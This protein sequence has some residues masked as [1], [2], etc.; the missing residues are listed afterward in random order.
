MSNWVS[1]RSSDNG[2]R[3]GHRAVGGDAEVAV[4]QRRRDR[5]KAGTPVDRAV[6]ALDPGQMTLGDPGEF[7][8]GAQGHPAPGSDLSDPPTI[9]CVRPA[10]GHV[11]MLLPPPL[12]PDA[13]VVLDA[14]L[15]LQGPHEHHNEPAEIANHPD[16]QQRSPGE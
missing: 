10:S 15:T 1:V 3:P 14:V 2:P 11:A 5:L 8:D 4:G 13:G 6:P 7:R 12:K 16:H 9:D